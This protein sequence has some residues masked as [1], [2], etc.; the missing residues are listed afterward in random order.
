MRIGVRPEA[1][2]T[3]VTGNALDSILFITQQFSV[4]VY[5][6]RTAQISCARE[7]TLTHQCI[8]AATLAVAM[9]GFG[10]RAAGQ[11]A[12]S[13]TEQQSTQIQGTPALLFLDGR[14][15]L[16]PLLTTR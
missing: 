12:P 11:T 4:I 16:A 8:L 10:L 15:T 6:H 9:A 7:M 1:C 5:V 14:Q 3:E 13:A 2:T